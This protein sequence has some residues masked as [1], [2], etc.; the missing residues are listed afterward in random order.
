MRQSTQV[1]RGQAHA[2]PMRMPQPRQ[3]KLVAPTVMEIWIL[4]GLLLSYFLVDTQLG[5]SSHQ[6]LNYGGP[7]ALVAILGYA[8]WHM[9]RKD[10]KTL[11]TSLF[12]F[13][14]STAVYFGL[15]T[16]FVYVVNDQTRVYL[17]SFYR[18]TDEE[19]F[20]LN[21]LATLSVISVL[22]AARLT[23]HVTSRWATR[24]HQRVAVTVKSR[25]RALLL[26]ASVSLGLGLFISYVVVMPYRMGWSDF[27]LP[28]SVMSLKALV[29]VGIF[30]FVLW[31][32]R[33]ARSLLPIVFA[34]IAV[35]MLFSLLFFAKSEF[36]L[37]LVMVSLAYL[38][39]RVTLSKLFLVGTIVLTA[40]F[41]I[42]PM[43]SYARYEIGLRYG[44]NA[45]A[46]FD[47]RMEILSG[48]FSEGGAAAKADE[49]Q[50][51]LSRISYVNAATF[52]IHRYD[53]GYPD[54]WPELLAAVL[55]PRFLW[56]EKPIITAIGQRIYTLGS[57]NEGSSSGAGLFAEA[58]WAW[59]WW[60][61]VFFMGLYG[62]AIG[63]LTRFA[64]VIMHN[65]QWLYFPVVLMGLQY[66]M[67]TD[68]HYIADAAGGLVILVGFYV[69]FRLLDRLMLPTTKL[70]R[71]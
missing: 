56:P 29:P 2:A 20:K 7:L 66:G 4:A 57:G 41:S 46:G 47:E 19:V 25:E 8:N 15:G 53:S 6:S 11:W 42:E 69:L 21:Q 30:L 68:G 70:F 65:G 13:R 27:I 17:E 44:E 35:E 43:V 54:D 59:G 1:A 3:T 34:L 40:Y 63:V 52:L 51:G 58:Y 26:T 60:G 5:G 28:G 16:F 55:V 22:I 33:N 23:L 67:R 14:L 37:L 62:A 48:Y 12:W 39:E 45:Q 64:S 9:A 36:L 71:S 31:S 49:M 24:M 50:G 32:R 38:W 10:P 61:V 18:F